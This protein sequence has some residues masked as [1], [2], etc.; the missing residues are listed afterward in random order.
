ML[1]GHRSQELLNR[2]MRQACRDSIRIAFGLLQ[3]RLRSAVDSLNAR[4]P[5][6]DSL[7]KARLDTLLHNVQKVSSCGIHRMEIASA[8][9]FGR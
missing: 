6:V 5:A 2:P 7:P 9:P 1:N 3:N 8:V 4:N